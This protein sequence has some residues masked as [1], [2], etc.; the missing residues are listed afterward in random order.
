MAPLLQDR[1]GKGEGPKSRAPFRPPTRTKG[2]LAWVSWRCAHWPLPYNIRSLSML[3]T[4]PSQGCLTE[5]R[6]ADALSS[7]FRGGQSS[8]GIQASNLDRL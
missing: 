5:H 1:A 6:G 3:L 7:V 2:R 8:R 4:C